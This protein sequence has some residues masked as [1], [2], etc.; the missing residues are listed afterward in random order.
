MIFDFKHVIPLAEAG[1]H[2]AGLADRVEM[3]SGDFYTDELPK[4]CDLALLSAIIHQNS[5]A[6]NLALYEK[7]YRALTPGGTLLIRDHIMEENRTRPPAGAIFA[8][9]M[10][11][12]TEDG[13]TYTFQEV[14][15]ALE[16][17]GFVDIRQIQQGENM[18]CIVAARK[19]A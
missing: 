17:A 5:P 7:I 18:D 15:S 9:N 14:K 16:S 12:G 6:Q 3:V 13:D 10:L 2:E 8:L 1:I 11:V 19:F 4:G